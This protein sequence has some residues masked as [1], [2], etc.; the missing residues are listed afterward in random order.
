[1]ILPNGLPPLGAS[2]DNVGVLEPWAP[3]DVSAPVS[4]LKANLVLEDI[5]QRWKVG[6]PYSASHQARGRFVINRMVHEYG[7]PKL[8]AQS[9]LDSWLSNAVLAEEVFDRHRKATGLRVLRFL[10]D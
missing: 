5:D 6:N 7:M 8:A 1:V 4:R 3:P 10:E 9:L 2:P